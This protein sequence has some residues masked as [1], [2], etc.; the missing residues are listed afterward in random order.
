MLMAE[1]CGERMEQIHFPIKSGVASLVGTGVMQELRYRLPANN[2][3]GS[4][5]PE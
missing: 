1:G 5:F 3:L 2:Q 4:S